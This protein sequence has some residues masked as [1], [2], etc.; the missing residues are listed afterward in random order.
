MWLCKVSI[1]TLEV[2]KGLSELNR[3]RIWK[4]VPKYLF[5]CILFPH[6]LVGSGH[7][8]ALAH[9]WPL[10]SLQSQTRTQS[11]GTMQSLRRSFSR[12]VKRN[13]PRSTR[14]T[15]V[16]TTSGAVDWTRFH[17]PC[18]GFA[19]PKQPS[20][21]LVLPEKLAEAQR[22]F[23]TLQNELQS[24]LDA[25]RE[26]WAN[27][28]G[29]RRRKTVFALSQQ[30]R[31]KHRNIK[32]LQLAFSEFYLSLILLQN[33]QVSL[34]KWP[35]GTRQLSPF[36][37]RVSPAESLHIVQV[38]EKDVQASSAFK[39]QCRVLQEVSYRRRCRLTC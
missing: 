26:S 31:C 23:A 5:D 1:L 13:S 22:R 37:S 20:P 21:F 29:L 33:Y 30:E 25:Q 15:P 27:G 14:S 35:V 28:R 24:S 34:H 32:D 2:S 9:L 6:L 7:Y 17:N 3:Q 38:K 12:R 4:T 36:I 18:D 10:L 11:R 16:M 8:T 19:S 39:A